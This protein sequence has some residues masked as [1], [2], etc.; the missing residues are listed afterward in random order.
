[1]SAPA[2]F[3]D[4]D[5]GQPRHHLRRRTL[6][7][8]LVVLLAVGGLG[9]WRVRS[10]GEAHRLIYTRTLPDGRVFR[11]FSDGSAIGSAGTE[12]GSGDA[13]TPPDGSEGGPA[14]VV[15]PPDYTEE[16]ARRAAE[17][18]RKSGRTVEQDEA[19]FDRLSAE[20]ER[21]R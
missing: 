19:E 12:V 15:R 3:H 6:L 18:Y 17:E 16:E 4:V 13:P 7:A 8:S 5:A 20:C 9:V 11:C 21:R 1:V 2:E 10:T 14:I